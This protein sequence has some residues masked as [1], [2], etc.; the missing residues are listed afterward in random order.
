[1]EF[2]RRRVRRKILRATDLYQGAAPAI[3]DNGEM[4]IVDRLSNRP[5]CPICG[6]PMSLLAAVPRT[7]ATFSRFTC[8]PCDVSFAEVARA[9]AV[10]VLTVALHIN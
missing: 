3:A 5:L 7:G 1:V 10:R 9:Q 8:A 4:D 2:G 6:N